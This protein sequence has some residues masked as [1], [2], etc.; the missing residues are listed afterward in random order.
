MYRYLFHGSVGIADRGGCDL[1]R[2]YEDVDVVYESRRPLDVKDG[3]DFALA[4]MHVKDN[5]I[6]RILL[7]GL[8][9]LI[10]EH[11]YVDVISA[12][13][14]ELTDKSNIEI[15]KTERGSTI[16]RFK[17]THNY[18]CSLQKSS[19]GGEP[20][21]WFG[22]T[23][24][25]PVYDAGDKGWLPYPLAEGVDVP[26]RMHMNQEQVV[27]LLPYLEHFVRTGELT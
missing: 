21:V 26:T 19:A 7:A 15:G 20:K 23:H 22:I 9:H 2:D 5:Y 17:D 16:L 12:G 18:D 27:K 3:P 10:N 14:T 6:S 1:I 8:G 25:H 24:P 11:S 4:V 13:L